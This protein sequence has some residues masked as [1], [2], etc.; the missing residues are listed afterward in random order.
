M[1]LRADASI[2]SDIL[3]DVDCS[4]VIYV[5][6]LQI[7]GLCVCSMS[8]VRVVQFSCLN[9]QNGYLVSWL[10]GSRAQDVT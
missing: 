9:P 3:C 7:E 5:L 10:A 2:A 4:H 8:C 6:F 1:F